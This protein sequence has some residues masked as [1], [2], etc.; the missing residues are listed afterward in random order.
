MQRSSVDLPEPEEPMMQV[1]SPLLAAK[2]TP[3][4]TSWSPKA[5]LMPLDLNHT[6]HHT[7]HLLTASFSFSTDTLIFARLSLC[8]P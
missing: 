1:T 3:R 2:S 6:F 5:F 4:S 7:F 8:E